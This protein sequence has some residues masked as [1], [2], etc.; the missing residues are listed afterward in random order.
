MKP[1]ASFALLSAVFAVSAYGAAT[2][3]VGYVTIPLPGTGGG[4]P[5]RLQIGNQGLLP[6]DAFADSGIAESFGADGTG[7]F[8]QDDEGGWAAG[9]Y[10]NGSQVSHLVEILDGPLAGAMT[11]ITSSE[12]NKLY[13]VDDISAAGAGANFRVVKAF[14]VGTL[15]GDPPEVETFQG[16]GNSG[17]ADN[18]LILDPVTNTY[19][20][21]WYKD[22]GLGGTGWR[23]AGIANDLVASEAIHPNDGLVIQRKQETDGSLVITGSVKTTP[24]S[25]RVE[26]NGAST[27]LNIVALT[28]PVDQLTIGDTGLYTGDNAT[29][30]KGGG[31]SGDADNL[32][33]F[34]ATTNTYTTFWYKDSG[35]G[36]TG[37]RAAGVAEPENFVIPSTGA[38]LIQRKAG[39]AFT[40]NVPAPV[41]AP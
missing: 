35:L 31:N 17:V 41:I 24:T 29:G 22:S 33:I 38:V 36:G 3:P 7:N 39:P 19:T 25:V 40:W 4:A 11:W 13:T 2:D 30:L 20:T 28:I 23:A 10:V 16:G 21:F 34:D 18:L 37:W 8:L 6:G 14:T 15:L 26:G 12:A 32:L 27:V 9:D 5:Q 1:I